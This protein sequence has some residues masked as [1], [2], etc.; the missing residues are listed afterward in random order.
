MFEFRAGNFCRYLTGE[1]A[2]RQSL[3]MR[4]QIGRINPML[5]S[6]FMDLIEPF[7]NLKPGFVINHKTLDIAV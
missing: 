4:D 1:F 7:L 2:A 3:L 5:S 6:Q